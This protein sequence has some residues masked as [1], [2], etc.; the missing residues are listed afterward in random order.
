[1]AGWA[2]GARCCPL[3]CGTPGGRS[4]ARRPWGCTAE[5]EGRATRITI[6][7][8]PGVSALHRM[9]AA[10]KFIWVVIV[11]ALSFVLTSPVLIVA[12][13]ALL[14]LIWVGLVN[15]SLQRATRS[16]LWILLLAGGAFVFQLV[17]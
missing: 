6:Q 4:R 1:M 15:V 8:F 12:V 14:F 17:A 16:T 10:S 11:G 3:D 9:D 5:A 13:K 2:S 7:Y